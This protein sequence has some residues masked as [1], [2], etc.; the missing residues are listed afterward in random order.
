MRHSMTA[1]ALVA[2]LVFTVAVSPAI[3]QSTDA[4]S[5]AQKKSICYREGG[6]R[7][8]LMGDEL[9]RFMTQC[10]NDA[11]MTK[12]PGTSEAAAAEAAW[13]ERC[14]TEGQSRRNLMGDQLVS[15]ID[16]CMGQ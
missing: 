1:A 14:R 5:Y 11:T 16:Q 15:F 7:E 8:N 4:G 12:V 6:L 9:A 13:K 10:M 2:V 3:A